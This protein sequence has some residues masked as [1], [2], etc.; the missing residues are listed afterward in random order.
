[1]YTPFNFLA[2][3]AQ[4]ESRSVSENCKW[5]ISKKHHIRLSG[6]RLGRPPASSSIQKA[7]KR[8]ERLDA[9]QRNA[10]EGKFG[11]GKRKYN[12]GRVAGKLKET[13]ECTIAMQFL[14]MNLE[15]K[16]RVLFLQIWIW[17]LPQQ[18]EM[19]SC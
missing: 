2:S 5:R 17:L 6:P 13:A 10:V 4:E 8:L 12:L 3:F 11:E 19:V 14:V 9:K 18:F 15:H 1:L 16:L 7:E